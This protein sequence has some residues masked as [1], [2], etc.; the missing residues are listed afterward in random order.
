MP[1]ADLKSKKRPPA[2]LEIQ[3]ARQQTCISF[4]LESE[5]RSFCSVEVKS[6]QPVVIDKLGYLQ[7][8]ALGFEFDSHSVRDF[9]LTSLLC[10]SSV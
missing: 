10:A 7:Q 9:Q 1:L 2:A 6:Y 8:P 4:C 5:C 3:C